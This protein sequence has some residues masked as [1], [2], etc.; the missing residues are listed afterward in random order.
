M[1]FNYKK[2]NNFLGWMSFVI[3]LF[4]YL[5]TIEPNFSFWDCGEYISSAVKLEVT[6]SPGAAFFQLIGA[7]FSIFAFGNG[8][9]YGKVINATSALYSAFTILFLFW[10]ISHLI[11]GALKKSVHQKLNTFVKINVLGGALI[12]SLTFIFTHTFWFSAVEGEVYAMASCFIAMLFWM[13]CRF[14]NAQTEQDEYR[15]I[16]LI[17]LILGISVGVHMM[18]LLVT[19]ALCFIYYNKKYKFTW[20]SFL[21]SNGITLLIFGIIF[22]GIFPFVMKVFGETEIYFVNKLRLPFHYGSIFS[23]LCLFNIFF[24]SIRFTIKHNLPKVNLIINSIL[25]VLI[26]FSCWLI[27]PIR[28]SSN[29][30]M[31]LNNPNNAIGMLDYYNREQYGDWPVKYGVNYT[32]HIAKDGILKDEKGTVVTEIRGYNYEKNEKE[33]KYIK[34]SE[35]IRYQFNPKHESWFPRMYHSDPNVM[36]NYGMMMGYPEF[37]LDSEY[38]DE[39]EAQEIVEELKRKKERGDIRIE[40]YQRYQEILDIKKPSYWRNFKF[41]TNYQIG[42]MF[43]RYFLWNYV[44]RQNDFEGQYEINKGNWVSGINWFDSHILG[45]GDQNSLPKRFKNKSTNYYYFLPLLLGIVGLFFQ[46]NLDIRRFY[47]LLSLFLLTSVGIIIYTN[48]RPF[49]PRDRDYALVGSFYVFAI[50]IG[51]GASFL[52]SLVQSKKS[53]ILSGAIFSFLM[54]IPILLAEENWDDHDRSKRTATYDQSYSYLNGLNNHAILFTYG[55]NDTYPLWSIQETAE[56]RTDVKVVNYT[57][58][59]TPWNIDQMKRRTYQ[60]APFPGAMEHD[61]Y[62]EGKNDIISVMDTKDINRWFE[63]LTDNEK[64]ISQFESLRELSKIDFMTAKEAM[65]YLLTNDSIKNKFIETRYQSSRGDINFLPIKK[66]VIPVNKKN[67]IKYKIVAEEDA[68]LIED[69]VIFTIKGS[70]FRKEMLVFLDLLANYEWDRPIYFSAGGVYSD[71]NIF[72]LKDYLQFEG[73][74]YKFVPIKTPTHSM[75]ELGRIN[76]KI[77]YQNIKSFKWGNFKDPKIHYDETATQ[78]IVIY[79]S[80]VARATKDLI[81]K[82]EKNKAKEL[83]DLV[84]REIPVKLYPLNT[85]ICSLAYAYFLLGENKKAEQ[86]ANEYK[87]NIFEE[88]DYYE[89]LH[90]K[91]QITIRQEVLQLRFHYARLV[92]YVANAYNETNQVEKLKEHIQNAFNPIDER[93]KKVIKKKNKYSSNLFKEHYGHIL[94]LL[95]P[96]D[97]SFVKEKINQFNFEDSL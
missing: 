43:I 50:W 60:S 54:V 13:I 31:N 67:A 90:P 65:K 22:K 42:F 30:P 41:F 51:M 14:E 53:Y 5:L 25:F 3:A 2:W 8:M 4:V 85:S 79:R 78:N 70:S 76:S 80:S 75:Q 38:L 52:I 24:F 92:E 23:F 45:L 95:Y 16:F 66:I 86:I 73:F 58:L 29:P 17:S 89:K 39:P 18:V 56:F 40:D 28:A 62:R 48:V 19:P 61:N 21:I 37:K 68:D 74:S 84:E 91:L 15:W 94:Q 44:G 81:Q 12:G 10:S 97:S 72:F 82:G 55:D 32:A 7:I 57:L 34:T 64:D 20:K 11:L 49:E 47:A 87:K 83:L 26:G 6:H 9:N 27:I 59:G 1:N 71:E 96:I 35:K 33:K 77:L 36:E 93:F 46:L 69:S 63:Y 88:L